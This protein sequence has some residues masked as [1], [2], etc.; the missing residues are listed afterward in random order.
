[1]PISIDGVQYR[2]AS[3]D[4]HVRE[5]ASLWTDRL[6]ASRWGERVPRLARDADGR[7]RWM[8]DGRPVRDRAQARWSAGDEAELSTP[9]GRLGAMDRQGVDVSV[10]YPGIAGPAGETFGRI[11]D[12]E[13][14][15]ACVRA[16]NDWLVDEWAVASPRFVPQC[17][18]PLYPVEAAVAELER[19]VAKGHRGLVYPALP[20][21]L[22]DGVPEI[23]A[24]GYAPLWRACAELGVPV[25]FH[26]GAADEIVAPV[27]DA[28]GEEYAA[29]LE[30]I[31][32]PISSALFVAHLLLSQ[33]LAPHPGLTAVFGENSLAWMGFALETMDYLV[34]VDRL[35]VDTYDVMP[36]EVFARQCFCVGSYERLDRCATD[37][38]PLSRVLWATCHPGPASTWPDTGGVL[39]ESLGHVPDAARRQVLWDNAAALYRL[40]GADALATGPSGRA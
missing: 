21:F 30:A 4:D 1:V 37:V 2:V 11:T 25:A 22:R 3:V 40:A 12:P 16:Y 6:P 13:L 38:V 39:A 32:E 9:D 18:V 17:L 27:P 33:V 7:P 31:N 24:D 26:S 19:A 5:P 15:L 8:V 10:L 20:Q 29:A 14:E 23:T 28:A 36:S 35:N 34:R